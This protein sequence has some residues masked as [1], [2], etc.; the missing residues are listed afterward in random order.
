MIVRALFLFLLLG[1]IGTETTAQTAVI[2]SLRSLLQITQHDSDRVQTLNS[3]ANWLHTS[4]PAE[5]ERYAQDALKRARTIRYRQGIAEA[6]RMIGVS[7]WIR[8][9]AAEAMPYFS[10][11][12]D[13]VREL[14]D[15]KGI[16]KIFNNMALLYSQ[17]S[18][19]SQAHFYYFESLKIKDEIDDKNGKALTLSNIGELF[20]A[21]NNMDKAWE[22]YT[23]T[24]PLAQNHNRFILARTLLNLGSVTEKR[25][26]TGEALEYYYRALNAATEMN[27]NQDIALILRSMSRAERKNNP[28]QALQTAFRA[29]QTAESIPEHQIIVLTCM[30]IAEIYQQTGNQRL[31]VNFA[32]RAL[33]T[34]QQYNFGLE[35]KLAASMLSALY[36]V[37]GDTRRALEYYKLASVHKDSLFNQE[38]TQRIAVTE[39][40]YKLD[41]EHSEAQFLREEQS[42]Q[43]RTL[44]ALAVI[45]TI[46]A[47][48]LTLTIRSNN[49]R[50]KTNALLQEQ[51]TII[52][53]QSVQIQETNTKLQQNNLELD[54]S[55]QTLA[56]LSAIGRNITSTLDL[57]T[58][59]RTMY[60]NITALMD[61][62]VFEVGII[63]ATGSALRFDLAFKHGQRR[64]PYTLPINTPNHLAT[65]CIHHVEEIFIGDARVEAALYGIHAPTSSLT[66]AKTPVLPSM[67]MI[68]LVIQDK[69]SG[70]IIVQSS[71]RHAYTQAHRDIARS[72]ASYAATAI[73]N[74]TAYKYIVQQQQLLAEQAREI[75]LT[76]TELHLIND[77]LESKNKELLELNNEKNEFLGIAAHDLKNP[78]GIIRFAADMILRYNNSMPL[79]K[80]QE[81]L[82]QIINISDRAFHIIKTLLDVNTIESGKMPIQPQYIELNRIVMNEI[83]ALMIS[84]QNK[85]ITLNYHSSGV[86]QATADVPAIQQIL[87]NLISNAVKYS[88]HNT[89]VYV[90]LLDRGQTARIEVQDEGPGLTEED[91]LRLFGKFAR[92]SA[93]PTGGEHSTGLGLS[94]VKKLVEAMNGNV[95][96]ESSSGQGATFI[97]ELPVEPDLTEKQA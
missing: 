34:A 67:M 11:S 25:G 7:L 83:G 27:D 69:A 22:Y 48:L 54:A 80:Q 5:S 93:K 46:M 45:L 29:L 70:I 73:E 23:K 39:F 91:K 76:N 56:T 38:N 8:S 28:T 51:N 84:A 95:W 75:E 78:L 3:L 20:E 57:E 66:D 40:N 79:E 88:P 9:R 17:Q 43:Q 52:E 97:V 15:K 10:E 6:L 60:D 12:L 74:A 21:Q 86:V 61:V 94:I 65:Y 50:K 4:Q 16:G 58:I 96:C 33:D 90:R 89:T 63:D 87:N 19:F 1:T 26:N 49:Q 44:Y 62:T 14:G 42:K 24:L 37:Q 35:S 41:R 53:Q 47:G 92:L 36:E 81:L 77:L 85:N 18:N 68:P 82:T 31:A 2:D 55:L 59:V 13:I 64:E 71:K 30:T 32:R 72:I